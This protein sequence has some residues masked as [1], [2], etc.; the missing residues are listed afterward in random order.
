MKITKNYLKQ[1]IKEEI[2]K[3]EENLSNSD[4]LK[5]FKKISL[6]PGMDAEAFIKLL[7]KNPDSLLYQSMKT[8]IVNGNMYRAFSSKNPTPKN[9][10]DKVEIL[11]RQRR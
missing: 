8:Q 11:L 9:L 7:D 6:E 1:I 3:I 10:A 2:E 5:A 4:V